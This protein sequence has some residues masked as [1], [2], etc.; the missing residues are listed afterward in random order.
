MKKAAVGSLV[1]A[2][3]MVVSVSAE[4]V[5]QCDIGTDKSPFYEPPDLK[6]K[7]GWTLITPP[8]DLS[9]DDYKEDHPGGVTVTDVN[10][11]GIDLHFDVGTHITLSGRDRFWEY[12]LAEPLAIDYFMSD[13][14]VTVADGTF[15]LTLR[16]L[17]AGNYRLKSYHNNP[18]GEGGSDLIFVASVTGAVSAAIDDYDIPKTGE[19]LDENIGT[20]M[21]RFVATGSGDVMVSYIGQDAPGY[22]KGASLNAFELFRD[23]IEF[24]VLTPNGGEVL[25]P[26]TTYEITWD[27]WGDINE[28]KIEYSTD[29]GSAWAE[30]DPNNTGNTGSYNWLIPE[31]DSDLCLVRVSD[32]NDAFVNDTSDTVFTIKPVIF[33][34]ANAIGAGTG[35]IWED[36][37]NHLADALAAASIG[38]EIWVAQG[39]YEP[40]AN[41][42]DP[43]GSGLRTATFQLISAVELYGGFP[44]G[45]GNW[46]TR[47]P[48]VYETILCGDLDGN[49]VD[50]N[51]PCDLASE[52][53]RG[54]N[55]WHVV[56]SSNTEPNAV[57]DGFTVTGGNANG[58]VG[59]DRGGGLHNVRG[60]P[61]TTNC[62]FRDNVA[63]HGGAMYSYNWSSSEITNCT[64]SG[65]FAS[66]SAG[67]IYVARFS[68]V[69]AT[70]CLFT[71]NSAGQTGGAVSNF[72]SDPSFFDCTFTT[73][74]APDGGAVYEFM[75]GT[76]FSGCRFSANR[77]LDGGG[78]YLNASAST[79]TSCIFSGNLAEGYG[80]GVV[81]YSSAGPVLSNCTFAGNFAPDGNA[82]ACDSDGQSSPSSVQ[83]TNCILWDGGGEIFNN[84]GSTIIVTFSDVQGGRSGL[85]NV[86]LDPC[87]VEPGYW[88]DGGDPSITVEPN[89]PNA[90]WVN[91]DY[92]LKS[93]GWR[94]DG[95][96]GRWHYDLVTSRCV[97][98][99]SPGWLLLAEPPNLPDDPNNEWG[100]NIRVNMG[101]YGRTSKASMP[102]YGWTILCD[103]TN[104]GRADLVDFAHLAAIFTEQGSQLHADLDRDGDVDYHDLR[105]L[106]EDWLK[107]TDWH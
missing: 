18:A 16:N 105:L 12:P 71:G 55:S 34:D 85:G 88:A 39:T 33:V 106:A 60:S 97:D 45:G 13:D 50:V 7:P 84:D 44:P 76:L 64:F 27:A 47:D 99:G 91:G 92:H 51:D 67:A 75:C 5:L 23:A 70:D 8:N 53:T 81:A 42:A 73:N 58:P 32:P 25:N 19:L 57:L 96:R 59:D 100:Q 61:T 86:H 10:G 6:L 2:L 107:T 36:A 38:A 62:V 52:P 101:A 35:M 49:D 31:I 68:G 87:F 94:W 72:R 54:E 103:T 89:D 69:I 15:Y 90:I 78:A 37:Y 14:A 9:Y 17:A 41:S 21:V 29:N 40:D 102:P 77:A 95:P 80:G 1:L 24:T 65:N 22:T 63:T 11:T 98:A 83:L 28:V 93:E 104:D 20:G 46:A 66:G 26:G 4:V 48:D 82:L 30:V 79:A 43:N 3:T 56:T 74:S